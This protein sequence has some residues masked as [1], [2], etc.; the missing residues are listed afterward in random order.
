MSPHVRLQTT[1]AIAT[2]TIDRPEK[3]NAVSYEMW[4]E[5][6]RA[7]RELGDDDGVR[8]VVLTGAG[9]KAFSAGADINDFAAHRSNS[10]QAKAYAEAFEG[11]LDAIEEMAKPTI[12]MVR[13]ICIGGGC[14]LA[15]AADLRI[16]SANSTFGVPVAKIAVLVGYKEMRRLVQLVGSGN[17]SALLLTARTIDAPEALRI[18]LIT[19]VV[20]GAEL[21]G[22][23]YALAEEMATYA[24]MSQA[25]HKRIMRTVLRDPALRALSDEERHLPFSI[26]DTPDAREGHDAFVEKR[27]PKFQGN[28]APF[29]GGPGRR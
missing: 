29:W 17:A 15:M 19:E 21:T 23:V 8:V 24:P 18:G 16:A 20:P 22:H 25:G 28:N 12:A 3:H 1:G 14:E 6:G 26:F 7:A 13:G 2:V 27:P 11:A 10:E 9:D 4:L 5:L